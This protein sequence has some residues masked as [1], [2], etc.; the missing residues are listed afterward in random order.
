[1]PTEGYEKRKSGALYKGDL[2]TTNKRPD[3]RGIKIHNKSSLYEGYFID[4]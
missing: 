1:M 4:G 2:N 3:G